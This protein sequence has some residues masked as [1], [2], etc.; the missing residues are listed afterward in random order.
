MECPSD[1]NAN[2]FGVYCNFELVM[3]FWIY[4]QRSALKMTNS[5]KETKNGVKKKEIA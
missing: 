5:H 3:V 4:S 1:K 2:V